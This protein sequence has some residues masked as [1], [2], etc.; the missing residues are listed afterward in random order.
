MA[1]FFQLWYIIYM[2]NNTSPKDVFL[3][4]FSIISLYISAGSFIALL[5]QYSNVLFPDALDYY[6]A[7]AAHGSIRWAIASLIIVFPLFMGSVWMLNKGYRENPATR[8]IRT[9]KWLIYFTLFAAAVIIA[10][11]L[12]ALV[13]S[14]LNG[15]LT[16]RFLLKTA[17]VAFVSGLIF[18]YYCKDIKQ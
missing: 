14:V 8:A 15:D 18:A 12:V 7:Q 11:D 5:F 2:E 9:R 13:Y 4:L 6:G 10:G 16:T 3:H 1:S 17:V